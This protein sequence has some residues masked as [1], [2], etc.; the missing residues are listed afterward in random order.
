MSEMMVYKPMNSLMHEMWHEINHMMG[1]PNQNRDEFDFH[2]PIDIRSMEGALEITLDIPGVRKEDLQIEVDEG[3]LV[4]KGEK[5]APAM[6]KEG[7]Y[8]STERQF[9]RF[10]RIVHLPED[11]N[12]DKVAADYHDGVLTVTIPRA[13][14]VRPEVKKIAVT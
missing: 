8:V 3:H 2:P 9:G 10:H 13:A 4:V 5:F 11:I 6:D 1:H 7:Q 14:M 12:P